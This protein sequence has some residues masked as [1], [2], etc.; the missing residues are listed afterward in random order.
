MTNKYVRLIDEVISQ[1][2]KQAQG[3]DPSILFFNPSCTSEQET[4]YEDNK[5]YHSDCRVLLKSIRK[6]TLR[7]L[8][9]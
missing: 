2:C 1:M 8:Q 6:Q 3:T 9:D 5:Y 4:S 7:D